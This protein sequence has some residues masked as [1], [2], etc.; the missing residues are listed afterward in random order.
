MCRWFVE[1]LHKKAGNW[2]LG[3]VAPAAANKEMGH[4]FCKHK[5]VNLINSLNEL[6]TGFFSKVSGYIMIHPNASPYLP[7]IFFLSFTASSG[8]S[9]ST[10]INDKEELYNVLIQ[11][12]S[13]YCVPVMYWALCQV[14]G[15]YQCIK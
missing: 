12:T 5:T 2:P 15:F 7:Y 13:I 14:Q 9:I 8:N 4:Q 1:R 6:G 10:G 11:F 3:R